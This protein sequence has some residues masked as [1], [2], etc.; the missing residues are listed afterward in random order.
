MLKNSFSSGNLP[1]RLKPR[2][3]EALAVRLKAAPF[4]NKEPQSFKKETI[5]ASKKNNP[6]PSQPKR[7]LHNEKPR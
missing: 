5:S 1:Q 4:K 7:K 3:C 6:Y 2:D